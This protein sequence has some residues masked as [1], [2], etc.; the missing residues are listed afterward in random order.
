MCRIKN[1][2][3]LINN[4]PKNVIVGRRHKHSTQHS[5]D[6]RPSFR[7]VRRTTIGIEATHNDKINISRFSLL[8]IQPF[9][10]TRHCYAKLNV[11]I[12]TKNGHCCILFPLILLTPIYAKIQGLEPDI[13]A[14][15]AMTSRADPSAYALNI[16]VSSRTNDFPCFPDGTSVNN[17]VIIIIYRC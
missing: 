6:P 1:P 3:I 17:V 7:L 16:W 14:F 15:I 13:V 2:I 5:L 8:I 4:L 10:D 9:F 11:M 12:F